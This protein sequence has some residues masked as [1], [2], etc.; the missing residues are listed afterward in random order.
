LIIEDQKLAFHCIN[1]TR[2]IELKKRSIILLF[3]FTFSAILLGF[4]VKPFQDDRPKVIVVLKDSNTDYWQIVKAG[5]EKGFRDFD[6][7]G[8]V[9]A[10]YEGSVEK[11]GDLLKHALDVLVVSPIDPDYIIPILERFVEKNI[12]VLLL[13]TDDPWRNKTA[14]IG[15]NNYDL[16][17]KAGALLASEFPITIT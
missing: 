3:L 2:G 9:I 4:I 7:N 12:P 1:D 16:G 14:Y 10:P 6:I 13:D 15:T 17:K 8:K 5:V 11:Q